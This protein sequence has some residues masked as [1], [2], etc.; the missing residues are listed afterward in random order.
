VKGKLRRSRP[1]IVRISLTQ[2]EFWILAV[3]VLG[4]VGFILLSKSFATAQSPDLSAI[5]VG[6]GSSD[7][8]ELDR[9]R[10]S[11]NSIFSSNE[12]PPIH[13]KPTIKPESKPK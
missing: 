12:L 7:P 5:E 4:L 11:Y 1:L 6:T 8:D 9:L 2:L 13:S 10:W 3:L